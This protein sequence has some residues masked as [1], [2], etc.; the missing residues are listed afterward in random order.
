MIYPDGREVLAGDSIGFGK[1]QSSGDVVA[2]I[3]DDLAEY[4]VKQPGIM[5][6]AAPLGLVFIPAAEFARERVTLG[7][8]GKS[9]VCWSGPS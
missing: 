8:R 9:S 2:V 5:V 6:K 4:N 7:E 3:A 1:A